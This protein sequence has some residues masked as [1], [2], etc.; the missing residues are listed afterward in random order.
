[1]KGY[2]W[3]KHKKEPIMAEEKPSISKPVDDVSVMSRDDM[4]ALEYVLQ[5]VRGSSP[6]SMLPLMMDLEE[7]VDE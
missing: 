3:L 4:R 2:D 1:M 7:S 5:H 6:S